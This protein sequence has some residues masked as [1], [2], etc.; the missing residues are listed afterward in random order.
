MTPRDRIGAITKEEFMDLPDKNKWGIW[1][2]I[3]VGEHANQRDRCEECR[4]EFDRKYE[5]RRSV[6]WTAG[7][8]AVIG[9]CSAVGG[10]FAVLFGYAPKIPGAK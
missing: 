3:M 4:E 2:E 1:F 5:P 8:V 9:V 7:Y 10:F 6:W